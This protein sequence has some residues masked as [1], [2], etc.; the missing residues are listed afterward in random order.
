M[1][2]EPETHGEPAQV[3][4]RATVGVDSDPGA[5]RWLH[6]SLPAENEL[7]D[8]DPRTAAEHIPATAGR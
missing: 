1:Q 5:T 6:P 4:E 3:G 2:R 7:V 8:R